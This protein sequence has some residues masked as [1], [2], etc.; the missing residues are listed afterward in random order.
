MIDDLVCTEC[1]MTVTKKLPHNHNN[2]Q[3]GHYL[4]DAEWYRPK[5]QHSRETVLIMVSM[6]SRNYRGVTHFTLIQGYNH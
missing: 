4:H 1:E 2:A 5:R 3:G 6:D